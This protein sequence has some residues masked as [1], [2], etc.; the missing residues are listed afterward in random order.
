MVSIVKSINFDKEQNRAITHPPSPLMILAGAGTGKTFTLLHRIKY[1]IK[2]NQIKPE[3]ILFLTFTEKATAEAKE[4]MKNIIGNKAHKIFIGTFHSFCHSIIRKYGSEKYIKDILWQENDI[5]YFLI[6]HFDKME[7]IQSRVF[8]N[9]PV[10]AIQESFIPFF[11]RAGDELISPNEL[12]SKLQG[13]EYS[14]EWYEYNFPDI[15]EK[16]TEFDDLKFQIIDLV[17]AYSFYQNQKEKNNALDYG[18]MILN[19]YELLLNN[20][21]IL[22][23]VRLENK[24]IFIDEYQDNNYALNKI[25]NLISEKEPSI[26]VVGDEDQCIYSFRGANYFNISDFRNRYKNHPHYTEISLINN[27]RSTQ[28]ILDLANAS[29]SIN[30]ERTPKILKCIK[31]NAD[32][33]SKPK[34]IQANKNQTMEI[35]PK[36]IHYLVNNRQSLYG[37]IA[38]ICRGRANV[39]QAAKAMQ[40]SAIPVDIYIEKFFDV[41]IVKD[42][43]SWGHLVCMD[44][45]SNI[46]LFRILRNRLGDVWTSLFFQK[47]D[48]TSTQEKINRL[49]IVK[50]ESQEIVSILNTIKILK[51]S[52]N[53]RLKS[54]EIVWQII[55][56]LKESNLIKS[57]RSE[58]GYNQRLNIANLGEI[59]N[60]SEQ[61]VNKD[62]DARFNNWIDYMEV[63]S[64]ASNKIAAQPIIEKHNIAV[65][66]MTIHQSKGLQF[67]VVI[68]PFLYSGSF[69]SNHKKHSTIDRVPATWTAWKQN[70]QINSHELHLAEERRVFYVGITRAEKY[71]YLM[72]PTKRESIFIKELEDINSKPME[73]FKMENSEEK[74]ISLNTRLQKL[75]IDLN[76]EISAN[77]FNNAKKIINDIENEKNIE[78]ENTT[79]INN[80][81]T[82]LHLS[83]TKIE[84]YNSCPLKYRLKYIDKVPE[85]KSRSTGEFGSIIHTILEEYHGL[86]KKD[87]TKKELFKLLNKHWREDAF[88]YRKR[89]EEF[90]KQGEEILLA[91]FEHIQNNHPNVIGREVGFTYIMDDVNVKISGKIDRIDD[92]RKTFGIVDYK[93]S[94]KKEKAEK[95]IQ[96]ALYTEALLNGAIENISGKPGEAILHFLR[97]GDDPISAHIFTEEELENYRDKI[98][99]VAI[100]IRSGSFETNKGDFNCRYCDYKEFLCPAWEE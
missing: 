1:L 35:L 58:Y 73:I 92:N 37:D 51:E 69:P 82:L 83:S 52:L 46:A 66:V 26:T 21:S 42:V 81:I 57:I 67:P 54:D 49:E 71:L 95:N 11:N 10:K 27:R 24:H 4:K 47:M 45:Y 89:G 90:R 28:E 30:K 53:K 86:E 72:G 18:D 84:T 38:V 62:P 8:A 36:L 3:H 55:S 20:Q 6:N 91:Y 87:Q 48:K 74:T 75:L 17:K 12:Q 33:G 23:K 5:L 7:F 96:M 76:R 77:Q 79:P 50:N 22:K 88:E 43:I 25:V 13:I 93:T 65:Q 44:D 56:L 39:S 31:K 99:N 85:R 34:W 14:K 15:H 63:L 16:N 9:N 32:T 59:L 40:E 78:V 70:K 97:F 80:E 60:L 98:R 61:F 41:P 100:G 2:S 68:M 19:C 94:R 64:L 29:I